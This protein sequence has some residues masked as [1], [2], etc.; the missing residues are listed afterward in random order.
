MCSPSHILELG[1][2]VQLVELLCILQ[3]MVPDMWHSVVFLQAKASGLHEIVGVAVNRRIKKIK[4]TTAATKRLDSKDAAF[5]SEIN[6]KLLVFNV[7]P[8]CA[9][10]P[11][12]TLGADSL[13]F[14]ARGPKVGCRGSYFSYNATV[15]KKNP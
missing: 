15:K 6:G 2:Q 10:G 1:A 4:T 3:L 8:D 14:Q 5:S 7:P 12:I 11:L 13:D 9:E